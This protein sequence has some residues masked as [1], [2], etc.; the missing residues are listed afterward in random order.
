MRSGHCTFEFDGTAYSSGFGYSNILTSDLTTENSIVPYAS[1]INA[2]V[3]YEISSSIGGLS[4]ELNPGGYGSS[5]I[6]TMLS[7][8]GMALPKGASFWL[9]VDSHDYRI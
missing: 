6:Q 4:L 5:F 7:D 9:T 8:Q 2:S 1:L 3:E